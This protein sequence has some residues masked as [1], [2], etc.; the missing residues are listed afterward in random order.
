MCK[1]GLNR[2]IFNFFFFYMFSVCLKALF[3][4]HCSN[5][6]QGTELSNGFFL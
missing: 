5:N 6:I 4:A 3:T 2:K 1:D